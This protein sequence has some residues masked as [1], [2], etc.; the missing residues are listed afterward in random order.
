MPTARSALRPLVAEELGGGFLTALTTSSAGN[1]G[2]TTLVDTDLASWGNDAFENWW[3]M[4]TSGTNAGE[5][6]QVTDFVGSSGTLTVAPAYTG[7]V[8][9]AVT[10]ELHRY[11]P[12]QIHLAL[13]E[14][15][16]SCYAD[17]SL[18]VPVRDETLV[19][20]NVLLNS[21]FET[22]A[23][24]NFTNWTLA[25]AGASVAESTTILWHGA[26]AAVRL[27]EHRN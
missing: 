17:G 7:Q 25:G 15:I 21:D 19:V 22:F 12:T 4:I 8:A 11:N 26:D 24:S 23:A 14:A 6:R 10:Y 9:S 3:A 2:G 20:D 13:N 1:A 5:W 18:W 16:K 27:R